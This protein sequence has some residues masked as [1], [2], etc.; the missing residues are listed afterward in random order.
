MEN[1]SML[2]FSIEGNKIK[3]EISIDDLVYLF[4]THRENQDGEKPIELVRKMQK[5]NFS[6]SRFS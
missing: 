5:E 3:A 6:I 2:Q 4:D 1:R